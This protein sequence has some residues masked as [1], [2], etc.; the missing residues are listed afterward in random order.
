MFNALVAVMSTTFSVVHQERKSYLKYNKLRMIELFEDI[1][2]V[3]VL[4]NRL[5]FLKNANHWDR[6]DDVKPSAMCLQNFKQHKSLKSTTKEGSKWSI[7]R[8]YSVL[9]VLDDLNEYK[10]DIDEEKKLKETKNIKIMSKYFYRAV[11]NFKI[12]PENEITFV[13][14]EQSK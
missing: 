13:K 3:R 12:K 8:Y 9:R 1:V 14:I 6:N 10:D 7:T 4:A 5:P 2:L 11:K